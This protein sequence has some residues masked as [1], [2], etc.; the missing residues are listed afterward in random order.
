M[1]LNLINILRFDFWNHCLCFPLLEPP[2]SSLPPSSLG[3]L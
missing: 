2:P 1:F 3:F